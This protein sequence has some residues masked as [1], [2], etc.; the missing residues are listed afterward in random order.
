MSSHPITAIRWTIT[1][2]SRSSVGGTRATTFRSSCATPDRQADGTRG[3]TVDAWTEH[4]DVTPTICEWLGIDVPLQ[5]DG[6]PLQPFLH[7]G[8]APA[9]WRTAAHWE[10]DFRNPQ[11][12]IAEDI[13]GVT[14]E[15]CCLAVLRDDDWKY[16][17]FAAGDPL[18]FDLDATILINS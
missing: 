9:D 2:W 13:L 16:V 15:Q 7:E 5:C 12:H 1:G 10:W 18:L 6:R 4:V 11:L 8:V 17:H 14:M 3:R